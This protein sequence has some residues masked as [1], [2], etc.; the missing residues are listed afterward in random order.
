MDSDG[1]TLEKWIGEWLMSIRQMKRLKPRTIEFYDSNATRYI[2]PNLGRLPLTALTS[3]HIQGW[4]NQELA[5][6]LGVPTVKHIRST[7]RV[8]LKRALEMQLV[9]TN[10][11]GNGVIQ[12]PSHTAQPAV[13]LELAELEAFRSALFRQAREGR[14]HFELAE[15]TLIFVGLTTGMRNEEIIGLTWDDIHLDDLESARV[16]VCRV[17]QRVKDF[18][19]EVRVHT[20]GRRIEPKRWH[21]GTPKSAAGDRW[22][23]L[24]PEAV[25]MLRAERDR[26]R[27][28]GWKA[29]AVGDL[30]F[31]TKFGK[32]LSDVYL[33]ERVKR[34]CKKAGIPERSFY[35]LR[36]TVASLMHL[37]G[38]GDV[39]IAE[40][41]GH[42]DP[43]T[44]K[45]VYAR[46]FQDAKPERMEKT[47]ALLLG[48][49]PDKE[50]A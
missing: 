12:V 41:M 26:Q 10:V 21:V 45:R 11:A 42:S 44:T 47:R 49:L 25:T 4:L 14:D 38:E 19:A 1:L 8:L 7:L 32:P 37:A 33:N 9:T 15:A 43:A 46:M 35:A 31:R 28:A 39:S 2:I 24:M 6:G 16:H 34:L 36:H 23:P 27:L 17:L 40:S 13:Q 18:D 30:V 5:S 22:L 50:T 3:L 48:L 29:L 20:N